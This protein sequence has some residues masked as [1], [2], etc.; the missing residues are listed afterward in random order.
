M[1]AQL[2]A[3]SDATGTPMSQLAKTAIE[4]F[5]K[6]QKGFREKAIEEMARKLGV[7]VSIK[8]K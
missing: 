4:G 7:D 8:G 2:Q 6:G 5:V 3:L 1:R